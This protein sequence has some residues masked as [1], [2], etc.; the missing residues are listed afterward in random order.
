ML[1]VCDIGNSNIVVG[2]YDGERLAAHW[3]LTSRLNATVD[4]YRVMIGSLISQ[5]GPSAG[6]YPSE[7]EEQQYRRAAGPTAEFQGCIL[8]SVVPPLTGKLS[9]V[10]RGITGSAPLEVG[11]GI[12]TGLDIQYEDP[13]EVGADRIVNAV[14][15]LARHTP[16]LIVI[17]FGTATTYELLLPPNIYVGGVITPGLY[18]ALDALVS[19]TAK[20]PKVELRA[21]AQVLGRNTADSIRSGLVHGTAA[22]CDGLVDRICAEH[23]LELASVTVIA[24][25]GYAQLIRSASNRIQH[26]EPD[27]TLFGLRELWLRNR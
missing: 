10:L 16:P 26:T 12:K 25:G 20:L 2:L 4:E 8:S 11:P 3:R 19:R 24:T 7:T 15:A 6:R 14:G 5:V 1:L 17:D 21:A 9:E 13:R 23:G 27:L 22:Q 18:I